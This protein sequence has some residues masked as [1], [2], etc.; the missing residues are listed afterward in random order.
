MEQNIKE[1]KLKKLSYFLVG[2]IGAIV[3]I[4][5]A[6]IQ[7]YGYDL[8]AEYEPI[9]IVPTIGFLVAFAIM[10]GALMYAILEE[11][12][13]KK[14]DEAKKDA[15][16]NV[17]WWVG[18]RVVAWRVR[19]DGTVQAVGH[20]VISE[21]KQIKVFGKWNIVPYIK[22]DNSRSICGYDYW[23][24][25]EKGYKNLISGNDDL[26]YQEIYNNSG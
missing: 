2:L 25:S 9:F 11:F 19:G 24:M 7:I 22:L 10:D 12:V 16:K 23:W 1:K 14:S 20:G 8:M 5:L 4:C 18:E 13:F 17:K 3:Y 15:E 6:S 26:S 21:K